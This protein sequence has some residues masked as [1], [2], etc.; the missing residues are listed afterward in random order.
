MIVLEISL[1]IKD[2]KCLL[3]GK[4]KDFYSNLNMKRINDNRKFWQTIKPNDKI[5]R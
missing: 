1:P 4:S 3:P 2:K 5:Q